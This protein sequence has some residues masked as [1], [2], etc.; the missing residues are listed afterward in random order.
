MAFETRVWRVGGEI[1]NT[2]TDGSP[3]SK[4][5]LLLEASEEGKKKLRRDL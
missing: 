2:D 5:I 4:C 1:A 3:L